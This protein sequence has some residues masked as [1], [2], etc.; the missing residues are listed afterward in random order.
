MN[1][2][3]QVSGLVRL[4]L[5][6]IR[7]GGRL[8]VW[9]LTCW[10]VGLLFAHTLV[11]AEASPNIVYIIADDQS[12]TDFGFMG[13]ERVH[14][15]HLDALAAQSA[16]FPNGYLTTSVCRPSLMTLLTGLYPCQ[17][18]V[19]FN[20][21]PP[22]NAG[23][24]KML[25]SEEY[26]RVR[27]SEFDFIRRLPTL[28]RV[29]HDSLG[30]RSFQTGKFWEGHWRNGGFTEGMTVFETPPP[31][32]TYGGIRKLASGEAVPHGNGDLGLTIGRETMQPIY[33]FVGNAAQAETP[34]LIVY[35]PLLPHQPHDSPER[36]YDMARSHPGVTK[37]EL[38][39][40]ASIAQFDDTVG[41]LVSWLKEHGK[42]ENT[43]IVFACD[44]GWRPSGQTERQRPEEFAPNQRSKRSPFDE[45]IRSPFL[46]HWQG[47]I[48]PGT[49]E[50]LASAID[51]VP[52]ILS[53]VG[54]P[55]ESWP[56][57]PGLDLLPVARGEQTIPADRAVYG[58]IYPGDASRLGH[59]E[60][61]VAYRWIRQG[62]DKLIVP[63][64]AKAWSA[65]LT[66]TALFD[67]VRDPGERH[68]RSANPESAARIASLQQLLD[69][70]WDGRSNVLLKP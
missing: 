54:L 52:T 55:R 23:F 45:G 46:L 58:A 24:N 20:H 29:L 13:N 32:Q 25:S 48:P 8:G 59:P 3:Y 1:A 60:D 57:L 14:T 31:G 21:G 11:S 15:P 70:W 6:G 27:S 63:R 9:L 35:A 4:W 28:P 65:Y 34:W 40:F 44:N 41:E 17:H 37:E 26:V 22:G 67:V 43:L 51:L 2:D 62:A 49:H 69:A 19:H 10:L 30:Y 33:D 68:D 18:G 42:W 5:A 12:W 50:G 39:Y 16:L 7:S 47:E 36:F 66:R 53:A 64:D 61:D 56:V 38:P